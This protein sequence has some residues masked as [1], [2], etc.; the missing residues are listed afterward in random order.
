MNKK[1]RY[2]VYNEHE[3]LVASYSKDLDLIFGR[4]SAFNYAKQNA[5]SFGGVVI[6]ELENGIETKMFSKMFSK[7]N[8]RKKSKK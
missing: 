5:N 2:K 3:E 7:K 4:G 6:E 1:L 8:R